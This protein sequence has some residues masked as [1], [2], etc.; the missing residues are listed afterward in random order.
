MI[1]LSVQAVSVL[2]TAAGGEGEAFKPDLTLL[3]RTLRRGL[4]D[5][6]RFYFHVAHGA[7]T[8]AKLSAS[9]V[10]VVFA[11]AFGEIGT[12]EAMLAQALHDDS[13]SPARFRNSVHNTAPGLLSI[14]AHNTHASTA[15]SAGADT[16]A[17]A[18]LESQLA[19]AE[20]PRPVLLVCADEAVPATLRNEPGLEALAVAFVLSRGS[21]KGLGR[22]RHLRRC[23]REISARSAHPLEGARTLAQALLT[24]ARGTVLV[25]GGNQPYALD[26]DA[27]DS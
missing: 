25:G 5:V 3:D 16:V 14:S 17:M 6:T 7:L 18:L 27:R 26:L 8:Q 13:A 22:L 12:A 19:L 11:S 9:D 21:E 20:N 4:S 23:A 24:G 2:P 1:A 10:H 15:L